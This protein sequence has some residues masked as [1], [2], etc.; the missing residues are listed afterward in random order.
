MQFSNPVHVYKFFL[1]KIRTIRYMWGIYNIYVFIFFHQHFNINIL[2]DISSFWASQTLLKGELT[3]EFFFHIG[4]LTS[5]NS[6]FVYN[7]SLEFL[8]IAEKY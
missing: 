5:I 3:S 8:R 6:H 2:Y 4:A 1:K 7:I